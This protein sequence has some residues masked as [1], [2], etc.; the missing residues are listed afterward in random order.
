MD[1]RNVDSLR[2]FVTL[3]Q[4]RVVELIHP[5]NSRA[6]NV[7]VAQ[8][9]IAAGRSTLS[10]VHREFEEVYYVLRGDAAME[11]NGEVAR[12]RAGDAVYISPGAEH[13]ITCVGPGD[14]VIL[15]ICAPPYRGDGTDVTEGVRV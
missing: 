10:H 11:L 5:N 2:E 1:I 6:R 4:S 15:C 3:D 14:L 7:S 13:R 9:T 12:M 8:A